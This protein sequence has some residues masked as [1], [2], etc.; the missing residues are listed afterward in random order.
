MLLEDNS[1]SPD[2]IRD[3]SMMLS[4]AFIE[5]PFY[6][7]I[8][9]NESS[10]LRKLNLW[11]NCMVRYGLEYGQIHITGEPITG[12]AIWLKPENPMINNIGMI[13]MGMGRVPFI[14]GLSG[15]TRMMKVTSEWEQL[16]KKET[17]NHWY[18][19]VLGVDPS[20]QGRGIGSSLIQP[21][22]KQAD[23]DRIPCYIE[24]MTQKDVKFYQNRGFNIV[25]EGKV[26]D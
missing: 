25:F 5:D 3:I 21:V 12:I 17:P 8:M 11:M 13:R 22:I 24:T 14:L 26:G 19:M 9:P 1:R 20:Y 16:H 4:R 23:L 7:Y 15:F 18:L 2:R 10:R 6:K